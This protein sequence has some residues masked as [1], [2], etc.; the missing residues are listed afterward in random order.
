[1][2]EDATPNCDIAQ[3]DQFICRFLMNL[4]VPLQSTVITFTVC[5]VCELYTP[6]IVHYT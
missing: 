6:K 5:G 2:N 4:T 3:V 1:M